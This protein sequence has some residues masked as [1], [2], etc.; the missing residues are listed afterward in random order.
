MKKLYFTFAF[1]LIYVFH[2]S[3]QY[4]RQYFDGAD[5]S[6]YNSILVG[7][8]PSSSN[9]WQIGKPQKTIF[10]GAATIPNVIVTDTKK[11][12]PKNNTSRF[13]AKVQIKY[14]HG[15]FALQWKQKLDMN[16]DHDGGIIEYSID[17]GLTW[18]NVFNNPYVQNFYGFQNSN[19]DTL[20]GGVYAFSGTDTVWKDIWL[21][22]SRSWL[23]KFTDND[24]A[25]FRFSF[26]S[27]GVGTKNK[28]GWM[29]D[30]MMG[31]PTM[32]HTLRAGEVQEDYLNVYPNPANS[33]LHVEVQEL[34][35]FHIIEKMELI[36]PMGRVVEE[37]QH[38]PTKFWFDTSNYQNG[39]Y[40][41]KIKTNL[42]SEVRQVVINR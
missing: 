33:I 3:A 34:M 14:T 18:V 32:I 5:T 28:E 10:N 27:D 2:S 17:N 15:I 21:C 20:Q 38:I 7:I 30:N 29:I 39:L 8:V 16:H 31:H 12:Y 1:L 37:W 22:F 24:T 13:I 6:F 41:L 36:D 9:I 35:E 11:V 19:R 40:F 42:R 25:L 23:T 4:Y 26:I